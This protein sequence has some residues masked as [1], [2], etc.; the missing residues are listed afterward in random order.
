[1]T[2]DPDQY[3]ITDC[4]DCDVSSPDYQNCVDDCENTCIDYVTE[5]DCCLGNGGVWS[6]VDESCNGIE[7]IFNMSGQ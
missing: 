3:A 1:M 5:E 6:L 2:D 7:Y 4:C